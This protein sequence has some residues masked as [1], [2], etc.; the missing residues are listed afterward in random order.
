MFRIPHNI[1]FWLFYLFS[2]SIF[3]FIFVLGQRFDIPA[4]RGLYLFCT[5]WLGFLFILLFVLFGYDIYR[6]FNHV[7][8]YITGQI[9]IGLVSIF[10]IIGTVNALFLRVRDV[11]IQKGQ[12]IG[13]GKPISNTKIVQL[14][15]L[16]LGPVHGQRYLENIVEKTNTLAPDYVLI[17]GDLADGPGK[18]PQDYFKAFDRIKAPVY[19]TT[20]NH[21]SYAGVETIIGLLGNTK[22]KV[23]MDEK[24]GLGKGNLELIG[25]S[26]RWNKRD[27]YEIVRK[28]QP[29][30]KKFSI[31][32]NHQPVGFKEISSL[33]INLMLSGHTHGGQFFPFTFLTRLVWRGRR[34]LKKINGSF[35]FV[36]NG[37]GT[38]G[39]PLRLGTSSEVVLLRLIDS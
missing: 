15:D 14:S 18:F 28:L 37:T 10:T 20:G 33:G 23:L 13:Q 39:P 27:V 30:P 36:S 12:T 32:M 19:F 9:I 5:I 22:V 16:H 38:W 1:W 3:I 35:M 25:I 2:S 6:F 26:N 21:E 8:P 24:V 4:V 17:T 34:G 29:D 11:S 7:D 31:L